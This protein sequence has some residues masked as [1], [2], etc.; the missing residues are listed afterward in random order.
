MELVKL[1]NENIG[2][3]IARLSRAIP[4]H[5]VNSKNLLFGI[6]RLMDRFLDCN[7]K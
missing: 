6:E 1:P 2:F 5:R 3:A 7:S 4:M